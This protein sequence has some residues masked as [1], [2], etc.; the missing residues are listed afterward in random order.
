MTRSGRHLFVL[1]ILGLLTSV[2]AQRPVDFAGQILPILQGSCV[3]CHKAPFEN[4]AGRMVEPQGGLRLDGREWILF[5][6]KSGVV[7]LIPRSC[8]RKARP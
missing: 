8:R 6:S 3:R 5:G 1:A 4:M 2:G 7:V